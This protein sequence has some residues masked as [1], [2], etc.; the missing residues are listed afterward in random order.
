MAMSRTPRRLRRG[1][2]RGIPSVIRVADRKTLTA[3][4]AED[5]DDLIVVEID[6]KAYG[7]FEKSAGRGRWPR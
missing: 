2:Q 5:H 1:R 6:P 7:Y 4:V 3:D